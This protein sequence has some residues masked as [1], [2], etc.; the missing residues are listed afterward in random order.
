M[1][2]RCR[3][4]LSEFLN[5][6]FWR[7]RRISCVYTHDGLIRV[8][9]VSRLLLPKGRTHRECSCCSSCSPVRFPVFG[10]E[11][12]AHPVKK[13]TTHKAQGFREKATHLA[14]QF[15]SSFA[16]VSAFVFVGFV[17]QQCTNMSSTMVSR[18]PRVVG[19]M[20]KYWSLQSS[21][22]HFCLPSS[23]YFSSSSFLFSN[24]T[25]R[26]VLP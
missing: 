25:F 18:L 3:K 1:F 24:S 8:F 26:Y 14:L 10:G 2:W 11:K 19:V 5:G 4:D 21:L 6:L 20:P 13:I 12:T 7:C 17:E 23:S 22:T 16:R 15:L 9:L